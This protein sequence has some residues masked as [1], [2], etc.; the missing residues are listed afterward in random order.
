MAG[1]T[2]VEK[3]NSFLGDQGKGRRRWQGFL[4]GGE[5][6][7]SLHNNVVG[8]FGGGSGAHGQSGGGGGGEYSGGSSGDGFRDSCGGGVAPTTMETIRTTNVVI[9]R[10]VMVR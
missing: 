1:L 4:Q 5:G 7:R 3:W 9:T 6:G 8:G 2:P 10:L